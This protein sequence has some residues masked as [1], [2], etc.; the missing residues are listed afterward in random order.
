LKTI[1]RTK[2]QI[3]I[4]TI[5]PASPLPNVV[6]TGVERIKKDPISNP[7]RFVSFFIC[8]KRITS[9]SIEIVRNRTDASV[10]LRNPRG[11][12]KISE[13]GAFKK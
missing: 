13:L 10:P 9:I 6:L 1:G 3:A 5:N 4:A 12:R 8:R 11:A 7:S 2:F